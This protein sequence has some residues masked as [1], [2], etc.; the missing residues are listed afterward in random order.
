MLFLFGIFLMIYHVFTFQ[1]FLKF[2]LEFLSVDALILLCLGQVYILRTG[3][4]VYIKNQN[5]KVKEDWKETFLGLLSFVYLIIAINQM[6]Q[7][8]NK[9]AGPLDSAQFYL[10]ASFLMVPG[11]FVIM[12]LLRIPKNGK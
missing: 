4:P 1:Y 5:G 12:T 11:Y 10:A 6:V 8:E 2:K 3:L 9:I 7:L